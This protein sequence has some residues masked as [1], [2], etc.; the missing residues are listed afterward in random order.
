M[1][2]RLLVVED[3]QRLRRWVSRGLRD[4]GFS[5]DE[6][7]DGDE[8]LSLAI[9]NAYDTIV[10]DLMLPG[11]DGLT[12]LETLRREGHSVHVLILTAKDT[13]DDRV[14]GLNTGA[15]DYLIKPFAFAELVAR[16][17]ALVRRRYGVKDPRILV[18]GLEIDTAARLVRRD[19]A[20]IPL[21]PREYALLEFLAMHRGQVVTRSDIEEHIYDE[22][23]QPMSNVV[24][25][26][27]CALR[28]KLDLPG[29]SSLIETR[30]GM[31]YVLGPAP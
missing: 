13:V 21:R 11:I 23:V 15:D 29:G 20:A 25:N 8:G 5:V 27:I 28:R 10:L 9:A 16:I 30:R 14:R 26:A 19:N 1:P 12:L 4:A 3:S 6:A 7:A 17:Q 24:D 18:G 22:Q 2:M 31:G